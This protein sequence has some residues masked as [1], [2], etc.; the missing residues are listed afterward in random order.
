MGQ[1]IEQTNKTT[2]VN[3][4]FRESAASKCSNRDIECIFG[5]NAVLVM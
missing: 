2:E 3:R 4:V 1:K 5:I